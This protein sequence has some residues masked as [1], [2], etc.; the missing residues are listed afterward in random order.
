MPFLLL[1]LLLTLTASADDRRAFD[2]WL[3]RREAPDPVPELAARGGYRFVADLFTDIRDAVDERPGRVE[4][5]RI[6]KTHNAFPIWAFHVRTP[7]TTEVHRKVLI[8]GG[9]HAMEWI[10]VEAATE[11]LLAAIDAPEPGVLVTVIPLLNP[12]G[13]WKVEQDL[14]AGTNPWRRGNKK[15]ID[16]NRDFAV[17]REPKAVWR[18]VPILKGFYTGPGGQ[19]ITPGPLSQPESQA[20]DALA[21]RERYDRAASLHA[22]GGFFYYPWAGRFRQP[23]KADRKEFVRLG[24]LMEQAQGPHAYRTKQ[25]GRWCFCFRAQG[26]ELDHLYGEY[27]T[28]AFL[29]ELTRTGIPVTKPWQWGRIFQRYNPD[30]RERHVGQ[31]TAAMGA[32]IR[33]P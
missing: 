4:I 27:G 33:E 8:F 24:H 22:W 23:P 19:P 1:L 32:L 26:A 14:R 11:T 6:G 9:I 3:E 10:A 12:D 29:V 17:N 30:D 31:A 5:E 28:K 18:H 7:G 15:N 20:L 25:L 2:L 16:L 13:R 21:A